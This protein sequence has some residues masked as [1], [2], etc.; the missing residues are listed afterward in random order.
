MNNQAQLQ[1][2]KDDPALFNTAYLKFRPLLC[3]YAKEYIPFSVEAE[4]LVT[5]VFMRFL[6]KSR[7]FNNTAAL[8]AFLY[9]SVYN[10]CVNWSIQKGRSRRRE[11]GLG[12]YLSGQSEEHALMRLIRKECARELAA[13]MDLISAQPRKV[14]EMFFYQGLTHSEIAEQM[15]LSKNTV[16]NHKVK[17]LK[18]LKAWLRRERVFQ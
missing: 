15:N 8:R 14:C 6:D 12:I 1:F 9:T 3:N 16:K 2:S 17:G 7:S 10:A 18:I 11:E 4:D 5:E 13:A